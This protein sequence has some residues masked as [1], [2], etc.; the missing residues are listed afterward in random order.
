MLNSPEINA[1]SVEIWADPSDEQNNYFGRKTTMIFRWFL[2]LC[3]PEICCFVS[4]EYFQRGGLSSGE[5]ASA[6]SQL[7]LSVSLTEFPSVCVVGTSR[8][9]S[10]AG[11]ICPCWCLFWTSSKIFNTFKTQTHQPAASVAGWHWSE[12]QH[13]QIWQRVFVTFDL[14]IRPTL[15]K[16]IWPVSIFV[17]STTVDAMFSGEAPSHNTPSTWPRTMQLEFTLKNAHSY[18]MANIPL[19]LLPSLA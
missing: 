19:T 15:K 5:T 13:E 3:K 10:N 12:N 17:Q 6:E 1:L 18:F 8:S 11:F 2:I 14:G 7:P 4:S 9:F 16:P